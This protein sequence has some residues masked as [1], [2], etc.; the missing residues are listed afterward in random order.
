MSAQPYMKVTSDFTETFNA[1]IKRFKNDAVLV[2][3]PQTEDKR[4]EQEKG[5]IGNAALLAINNFGSPVNNIPARPVMKI[6]IRNAQ[7]AIAEQFKLAA[8]AVLKEG[9]SAITKYYD[10]AGMVA[11][12]AIKKAINDQD[13]IK[14]PAESTLKARKYLTQKGFKGTKALVVTGQLRN[15]ITWVLRGG[16]WGK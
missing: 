14:P 15:A 10:R 4:E 11:S 13:G 6:G 16:A 3:I 9:Q 7:E 1:A 5:T 2:G 8:R 12:Q